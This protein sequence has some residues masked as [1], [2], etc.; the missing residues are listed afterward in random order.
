MRQ[1]FCILSV[2]GDLLD[3]GELYFVEA[4]Q[5]LDAAKARV[6]SLAEAWPGEYII[7]DGATGERVIITAPS[8]EVGR[9]VAL[10]RRKNYARAA[11]V[12]LRTSS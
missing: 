10:R 9:K 1:P 3:N 2:V 4:T 5:S 7:Y 8:A 12:R 11:R 6:Q